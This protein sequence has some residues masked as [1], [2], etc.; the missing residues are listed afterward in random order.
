MGP[1]IREGVKHY[2]H[3]KPK[4]YKL[5]LFF[6]SYLFNMVSELGLTRGHEFESLLCNLKYLIPICVFESA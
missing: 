2:I 1:H 3:I 4:S 6:M 5:E